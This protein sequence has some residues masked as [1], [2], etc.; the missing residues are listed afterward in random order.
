MIEDFAA[1]LKG[2]AQAGN[3]GLF[4]PPCTTVNVGRIEGGTA[5]N[6]VA[7]ECKFLLEWRPVPGDAAEMVPDAVRALVAELQRDDADFLCEINVVRQ[8]AGFA[9][10]DDAPL[11]RRWRELT[12]LDAI[13]VSFGT[14]APLFARLAEDVIVVG[15]GDMRTAHSERECVPIAELERCVAYLRGLVSGGCE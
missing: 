9:T 2:S 10:R 3:D 8:H 7:G 13:G 12:G 4:D 5:K 11:L 14:E 15:P 6:I 1:S